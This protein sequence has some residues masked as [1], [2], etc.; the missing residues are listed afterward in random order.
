MMSLRTLL[1]VVA[2]KRTSVSKLDLNLLVIFDAIMR[3]NS[4]TAAA[5]QLA[6]T[7]P[8]V[9]NAVSRMRHNWKDPLFVKDGRG[10][11]PTPY[12]MALWGQISGSLNNISEAVKPSQFVPTHAKRH[13][14]IGCT[15]G[16]TALFWPQLRKRIEQQAPGVGIYS[17][18]YQ[19]DGE[20]LLLA[21]QADL[22]IDCKPCDNKQIRSLPI[23]DQN[24]IC[25]MGCDNP[26][27][28]KD[29]TLDSFL[30]AKHLLI[31]YSGD[32]SG[33]VDKKLEESGKSRH[34]AMTVN[35]FSGAVDLIKESDLICVMPYSIAAKAICAGEVSAKQLPLKLAPISI[36]LAWHCRKDQ[37]T[38]LDWLKEQLISIVDQNPH[39]FKDAS[40]TH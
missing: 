29:L 20:S 25:I 30:Q 33:T 14:R 32:P 16:M 38:G 26:L 1:S 31:S 37:D 3:E 9:S 36:S 18:P 21:A 5:Q 34:I 11:K 35:S 12:A 2:A 22:V 4:I 8:S 13:F 19:T 27:A 28:T 39:I 40:Q 17:I 15:D 6:M 7:Q 24:F 23:F 10:M